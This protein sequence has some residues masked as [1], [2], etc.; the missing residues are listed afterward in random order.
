MNRPASPV[1]ISVALG[2]VLVCLVLLPGLALSCGY[3]R[4][5]PQGFNP[6]N[7]NPVSISQL[8]APRQAGLTPGQKVYV[9]GYFW[10][11]LEYD[12]DMVANYLTLARQPVAWSRLRWAS[13]YQQ[14]QM[15]GYYDRLALTRQ[16]QQDW[17]LR[18][19]EHLRVYGQLAPLGFGVLYLQAHH[20]E[21]LDG[22]EDD[23]SRI[24]E[25]PETPA[26]TPT[27]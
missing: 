12:P 3:I 9:E 25:T 14:P 22:A 2:R 19:L 26:E 6:E 13:L 11:Y 21:R 18:R 1:D 17:R 7:Y 10:Q 23:L 5:V 24:D 20:L 16:Q 27:L 8:M 4:P 15:R